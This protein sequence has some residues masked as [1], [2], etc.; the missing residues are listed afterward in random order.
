MAIA[1]LASLAY[2]G[3]LAAITFVR[4]IGTKTWAE[5][6][7]EIEAVLVGWLSNLIRDVVS[8]FG[9]RYKRRIYEEYNYFN[10]RGLGLL[11]SFTLDLTQVFVD[12]RVS[13]TPSAL[14]SLVANFPA[15]GSEGASLWD[16][17]R[18]AQRGDRSRRA[19]A[20]I[21][22]PGSGKT[23]LL[24]HVALTFA[25]NRQ[26][27]QRL[28]PMLPIV[29]FLRE[30]SAEIRKS[31][32]TLGELAETLFNRDYWTLR[33]PKGWF[34][35]QLIGRRCIVLLDGL[36][37]VADVSTR[38]VVA[39]W[40]DKQI[41]NY[42]LARFLITARPLGYRDAPL[43]RA[44]V[45]EVLPFKPQQVDRFVRQWY[46]ANAVVAAGGKR[47]PAV[48]RRSSTDSMDLLRRL[49]ANPALESLTVNP[50]LLT[51]IT[52]VHRFRGALPGSRVELYDEICEVL[53][54]RWRQAKGIDDR[55][56]AEQKRLVLQPLA[57]HMMN[58]RIREISASEALAVIAPS[59][60]R[61]GESA[62]VAF[63]D[64]LQESSGLLQEREPE[65]WTFAHLTFQEFLAAGFWVKNGAPSEW[66]ALVTDAW[67]H[68]SIRL[69]ASKGDATSV[70]EA[71]L[72]NRSLTAFV[73]AS[74][75]LDEAAEITPA[76]RKE[77]AAWLDTSLDDL[78][79]ERRNVAAEVKLRRRLK[80]FR[81]VSAA[82]E[83]YMD[84]SFLTN[85]EYELFVR[86]LRN[87]R[88]YRALPPHWD[89]LLAPDGA[90]R[91]PVEGVRQR[92]VRELLQYLRAMDVG[93]SLYRLPTQVEAASVAAEAHD[94][95][96][97]CLAA[98]SQSIHI[99]EAGYTA[100]ADHIRSLHLKDEP[101]VPLPSLSTLSLD[102]EFETL[103]TR[104]PFVHTADHA[105][106]RMLDATVPD[107]LLGSCKIVLN[108]S[109]SAEQLRTWGADTAI[110]LIRSR[111]NS[112][113][114]TGT[115]SRQLDA[116]MV[117]LGKQ[118]FAF[119]ASIVDTL[120]EQDRPHNVRLRRLLT[121]L[122]AVAQESVAN[123]VR[124]LARACVARMAL[125]YYLSNPAQPHGFFRRLRGDVERQPTHAASL[126]WWLLITNDRA[127][128]TSI[129]IDCLR[130]VRERVV[131]S[132]DLQGSGIVATGR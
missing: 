59:L 65:T 10:V 45:L 22:P 87:D 120:A 3:L 61:V 13:P 72:R 74:E 55:L 37:E 23:T 48:L 101:E 30:H 90:R 42:P 67:W 80:T 109:T 99:S 92:S 117:K 100:A 104:W 57:V 130:L 52:M 1:L 8:R 125:Y 19:L 66:N 14:S 82:S 127:K 35:R 18:Y 33:P 77:A 70:I 26:A 105:L 20:I 98:G 102:P 97:V 41:A 29:L 25:R 85:A 43:R 53:L 132:P 15:D 5:I 76:A 114:M 81:R 56:K 113:Y 62:T 73:L 51:M 88:A 32:P 38:G 39:T 58:R 4:G 116:L 24:Q 54:G 28:R 121:D 83:A 91:L 119:G 108:A 44:D 75:C 50:L 111:K 40:V 7:P 6:G 124:I 47:T 131:S 107:M 110:A 123:K 69:Y 78:D 11:D 68:E 63:L 12:L 94:V 96:T 16:F 79:E 64:Y 129:P 27:R 118:D 89:G 112:L 2:E 128:G 60:E 86:S 84:A 21:G 46:L 49:A 103:A 93:I 9:R 31:D 17:V 34:E 115:L 126:Y 71:C 106:G 36:D 95:G 122:L